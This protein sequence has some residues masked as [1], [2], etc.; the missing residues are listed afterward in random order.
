MKSHK[1]ALTAA[2]LTLAAA[3]AFAIA[4]SAQAKEGT[5]DGTYSL[6]ATF[7][8][9]QI[10]KE[11]LLTT[12]DNHGLEVGSGLFD[13]FTWHCWG[14]GDFAKGVGQERGL[15]AGTDPAGDQA[16]LSFVSEK[17]SFSGKSSKGSVTFIAGTGKFTDITGGG[18]YDCPLNVFRAVEKGT[19]LNQCIIHY[20][21]K[22]P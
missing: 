10:G 8:A 20:S 11:R 7:N 17:Y 4:T 6:Y 3:L 5:W 19:G 2:A 14:V 1:Y 12:F 18:T 15:C 9:T 16:A 21:Y 13:H 22:L